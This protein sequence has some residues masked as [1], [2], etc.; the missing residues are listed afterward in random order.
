MPGL[1]LRYATSTKSSFLQKFFGKINLYSASY[2][3]KVS[4]AL[5]DFI[6]VKYDASENCH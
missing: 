3:P 4:E 6:V 2:F 5:K 1:I